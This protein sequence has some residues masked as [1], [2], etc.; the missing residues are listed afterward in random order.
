MGV[1]PLSS[2]LPTYPRSRPS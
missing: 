1:K 2:P